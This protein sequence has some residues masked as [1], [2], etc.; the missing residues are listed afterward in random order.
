[1]LLLLRTAMAMDVDITLA[2]GAGGVFAQTLQCTAAAVH[3]G[4]LLALPAQSL[5][6]ST[7]V[8]L[9]EIGSVGVYG[10]VWLS[11]LKVTTGGDAEYPPLISIARPADAGAA[12]PCAP[13]QTCTHTFERAEQSLV[14]SIVASGSAPGSA[15][16]EELIWRTTSWYRAAREVDCETM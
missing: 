11:A 2:P 9:I 4:E 8:P 10:V 6:G 15:M 3:K 13:Q 7:V 5:G 16:P 12:V 14:L 1:M